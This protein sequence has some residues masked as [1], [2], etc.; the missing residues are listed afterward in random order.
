[1]AQKFI[2]NTMPL[3]PFTADA[4]QLLEQSLEH[5]ISQHPPSNEPGENDLLG[6]MSGHTGIAY[7]LLR[8]SERHP[9][10]QIEG[11]DLLYWAEQYTHHDGGKRDVEGWACGFISERLS[12]DAVRACITR[13]ARDVDVFVGD[14][15]K[16]LAPTPDGSKNQYASEMIYG[17]AGALYLL[18]LVRHHVPA[19]KE[20][21]DDAVD[22]L[23]QRILASDDDGNGNWLWD[24]KRYFGTAHGDI[25]IITQLVLSKPSLAPQ[26]EERV[27]ALLNM[28]T[29]EGNWC[30]NTEPNK[31]A[32]V[33]RVQYCHGAP[34]Y[35]YALQ[36]LREYYPSLKTSMDTAIAKAREITW[37]NGL[38]IK[39]PNL[40]H[41]LFGNGL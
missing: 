19:C 37:T 22:K 20:A 15:P 34:G 32:G 23:A 25:G 18:R 27:A 1:M 21:V 24:G 10:L 30:A 39:E 2:P 16:L 38:L 33:G 31:V 17:R 14:M 35:V 7:L 26:L 29:A 40:C 3:R 36:S 41:G 11:H 6:I 12:F 13:D 4:A 8:L 5:L 28:Q 9:G